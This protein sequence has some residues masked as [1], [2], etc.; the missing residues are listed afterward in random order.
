ME[1]SY[2]PGLETKVDKLVK[3]KV[4][5]LVTTDWY[6]ISHRLTLALEL[7]NRGY[8]VTVITGKG[9]RGTEI[10]AH[11]HHVVINFNRSGMNPLTEFPTLL[12]ICKHYRRLKPDIV[13]HIAL[14]PVAYGS[15]AAKLT[16]IPRVINTIAG[17]GFSYIRSGLRTS[18]LRRMIWLTFRSGYQSG[19]TLTV[20]QNAD[21]MRMF[22]RRRYTPEHESLLIKGSG[23]DTQKFQPASNPVN[24]VPVVL[25][26]ARML[27]PKG[28]GVFVEAAKIVKSQGLQA[29]FQLAGPADPAN[30][31]AVPEAQ[32]REWHRDGIVEWL[33][34]CKNMAERFGSVDIVTLPSYYREGIPLVLLEAAASGKPLITTLM[35]G[36]KETV[37]EGYNGYLVTP[38]DAEAL[39]SS[40]VRLLKDPHL[41]T[42]MGHNSRKLALENF[43][44]EK[45]NQAYIE[46][47][48][49]LLT[50]SSRV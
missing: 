27:W 34:N 44:M 36:C 9:D 32:L 19:K 3:P 30:K 35:P 4:I 48:N 31:T 14:K 21:D 33:G 41:R 45:I 1:C 7:K 25:L 6:F 17:L 2:V 20:F 26:P 46:A 38:N 29:K 5:F 49:Q 12:Q 40:I 23:V 11:F 37:S 50:P 22:I 42:E 8:S 47:Y 13:H 16:G 24:Q 39:A 15:I 43:A 10:A 28:V 18:L